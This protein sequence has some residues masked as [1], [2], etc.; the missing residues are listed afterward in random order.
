MDSHIKG[1]I[2]PITKKLPSLSLIFENDVLFCQE[3]PDCIK[4]NKEVLVWFHKLS[5][6]RA[7]LNKSRI[8]YGWMVKAQVEEV[9]SFQ[10][11]FCQSNTL[12]FQYI[13][14]DYRYYNISPRFYKTRSKIEFYVANTLSFAGWLGM[15]KSVILPQSF[16]WL[17]VF[18][19]PDTIISLM[20]RSIR[21]FFWQG[22][23]KKRKSFQVKWSSAC[24]PKQEGGLGIKSIKIW[25]EDTIEKFS[26]TYYHLIL[27]FGQNGSKL[28][29]VKL[30]HF[31]KLLPSH[32]ILIYGRL[33]QAWETNLKQ[34]IGV[35]LG[36]AKI[37]TS[38]L[39]LGFMEKVFALN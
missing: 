24:L 38:L 9:S 12:E 7:N 33:S 10:K 30:L 6:W 20:E 36:M 35:S 23:T 16:Y 17:Q 14:M 29:T 5:G 4:N 15:I 25:N 18:K 3:R 31:G 39:I 26:G 34:D 13:L 2:L 32:Q 8:Y 37:H 1:K 22:H 11:A 27:L 21:N 28:T 19:L